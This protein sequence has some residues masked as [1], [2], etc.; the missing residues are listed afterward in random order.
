MFAGPVLGFCGG[1]IDD[2]DGTDSQELGPTA[3]Q[4]EEFPC[5]V[6]G[7]C[8]SPLGP[9]TLGLIYVNPAGP[10]GQ[11]YPNI[12]ATQIRDSFDRM[13]MNDSETVALIGGGHAF[14]KAHGACPNGAGPSP[15]MDPAN[16][17]PGLCGNGK[18]YFIHTFVR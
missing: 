6:D 1:R 2:V 13:G 9:T 11:P 8:K 14:G 12:S 3:L 18:V 10:F 5:S 17:Y 16:P 15:E 7:D 4:A